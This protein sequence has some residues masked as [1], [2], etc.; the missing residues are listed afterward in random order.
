MKMIMMMDHR[1]TEL[2]V[3][4]VVSAVRG[5]P[6][7]K[8]G[9]AGFSPLDINVNSRGVSFI[10]NSVAKE[11]QLDADGRTPS[12]TVSVTVILSSSIMRMCGSYH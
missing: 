1:S 3:E 6:L 10:V 11:V 9:L 12:T 4:S 5:L 7:A 8:K 2:G